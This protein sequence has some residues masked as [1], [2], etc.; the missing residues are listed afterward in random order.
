MN[1]SQMIVSA[2]YLIK[3]PIL[4]TSVMVAAGVRVRQGQIRW[5]AL[6]ASALVILYLLILFRAM[7]PPDF[8]I[9]WRA[10]RAGWSPLD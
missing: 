10:G 4:I 9:F 8:H 5:A 2:I 6:V 1:E 3:L 7:T